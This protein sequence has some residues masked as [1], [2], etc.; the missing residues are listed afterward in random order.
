MALE[1]NGTTGVSLVQDGVV[2][3]ADLASGAITSA[4]LP[5]GSVL[6][7]VQSVDNTLT[8]STVTANS[9]FATP[10]SG[11]ITPSSTS[12][13][14][15]V[16]VCISRA[17]TSGN[18]IAFRLKRG[19][20]IIGV[21]QTSGS[22]RPEESFGIEVFGN[23]DGHS[24]TAASFTFLDSPSTTSSTTYSVDAM[25]E[26]TTFTMNRGI[27]FA[28]ITEPQHGTTISTITLMEIAG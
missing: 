5:A 1:L 10:L 14:V 6:Q 16:T 13:K 8:S 27:S 2:T 9:F 17:H 23:D 11:S 3:A 28:D 12:N 22:N 19:G 26:G 24:G 20:T 15:L 25:A 21:G 4:A 18:T 7:V